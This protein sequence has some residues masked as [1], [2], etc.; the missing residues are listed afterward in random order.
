MLTTISIPFFQ[1]RPQMFIPQ[2][3]AFGAWGPGEEFIFLSVSLCGHGATYVVAMVI[4]M[5]DVNYSPMVIKMLDVNY[6]R[7]PCHAMKNGNVLAGSTFFNH[8]SYDVRG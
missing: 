4:K 1:P 5:L 3:Q 6:S 8:F 7:V 2:L